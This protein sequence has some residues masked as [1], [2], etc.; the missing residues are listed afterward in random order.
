MLFCKFVN[1]SGP[2]FSFSKE[3]IFESMAEAREDAAEEV[4]TL[5]LRIH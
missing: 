2:L 4:S 5:V 1:I 3:D